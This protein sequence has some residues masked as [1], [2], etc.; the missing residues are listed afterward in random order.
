MVIAE[1]KTSYFKY[2][3][4]EST[5]TELGRFLRIIFNTVCSINQRFYQMVL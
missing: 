2:G 1:E 5:K 4:D 3:L